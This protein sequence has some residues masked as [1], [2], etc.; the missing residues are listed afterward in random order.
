MVKTLPLKND[1]QFI[2]DSDT[3]FICL[4]S[5]KAGDVVYVEGQKY[6]HEECYLCKSK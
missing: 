1:S 5:F 3:C 6:Y 4:D 2:I